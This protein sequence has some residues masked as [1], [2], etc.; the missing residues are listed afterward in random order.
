MKINEANE[1]FKVKIR[2]NYD[3]LTKESKFD[4]NFIIS[5]IKYLQ[6]KK[7]NFVFVP[8]RNP[9]KTTLNNY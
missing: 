3:L 6:N 4:A 7:Y 9:A 2:R 8:A 5:N 1:T